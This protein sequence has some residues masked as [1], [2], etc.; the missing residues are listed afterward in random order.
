MTPKSNKMNVLG[1]AWVPLGGVWARLG[2][3]SERL[4][5][6]WGFVG[7]CWGVLWAS[8]G[9]VW[10]SWGRLDESCGPGRRLGGV[11]ESSW[12]VLGGIVASLVSLG[13]VLAPC[14]K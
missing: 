5:G 4:G 9:R 1:S 10:A 8:L 14:E 7:P 12:S 6:F 11:L 3:I 2:R 13:K